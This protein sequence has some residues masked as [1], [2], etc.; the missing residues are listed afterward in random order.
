M[1]NVRRREQKRAFRESFP[2]WN[3]DGGAPLLQSGPQHRVC[4]LGIGVP[5]GTATLSCPEDSL[6]L[7]F[8][9]QSLTSHRSCLVANRVLAKIRSGT[10]WSLGAMVDVYTFGKEDKKRE[11]ESDRG[12]DDII[13]RRKLHNNIIINAIFCRY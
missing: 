13:Y 8:R 3:H 9:R 2:F 4:D 1:W 6:A 5:K 7:R 10:K 12:E 11:R